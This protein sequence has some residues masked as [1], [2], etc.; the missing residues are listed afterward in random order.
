MD[1]TIEAHDIA[2][3]ELAMTRFLYGVG[4]DDGPEGAL[5]EWSDEEVHRLTV[6]LDEDAQRIWGDR[7]P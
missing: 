2:L 1:E 3:W 5:A 6:W 4:E 7:T